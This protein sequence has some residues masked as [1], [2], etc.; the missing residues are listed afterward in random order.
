MHHSASRSVSL[1]CACCLT[2][3]GQVPILPD[4]TPVRIRLM[5]TISSADAQVGETVDFEVLE[6]VEIGGKVVIK[7]G[8]TAIATVTEAVSK[9]RMGRAGKLNLNIDY[10]RVASGEK[11]ALRAVKEGHGGSNVGKM[12]GAIV[13]T[14]IIFFPAAPLFLFAKGKDV[15]MP[16]GHEITAYVIGDVKLQ[17]TAGKA[18]VE[19]GS[20]V[21]EKPM[22]KAAAVP[23]AEKK[24]GEESSS[25]AATSRP[26]D[27]PQEASTSLTNVT[28]TQAPVAATI[29]ITSEP[30]GADVEIDGQFFGSAGSTARLGPG[31]YV[32]T[33]NKRG[34]SPW[35]RRLTVKPGDDRT[36]HADLEK[37]SESNVN[38]PANVAPRS[39]VRVPNKVTPKSVVVHGQGQ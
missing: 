15:V 38:A 36:L 7:R 23:T 28:P 8:G 21:T 22:A 14:S 4:G 27:S 13:A 11:V 2:I 18:V 16:K 26:T 24:P 29:K 1:F 37:S 17:A 32:I 3:Q 20:L 35:Q 39:Q 30:A 9:R 12:T 19:Q 10:V 25:L 31:T 33:V 34:Y 6:D 5:R